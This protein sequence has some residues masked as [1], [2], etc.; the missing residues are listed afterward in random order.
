LQARR[1][2]AFSKNIEV[3]VVTPYMALFDFRKA[4]RKSF[5]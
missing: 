4:Y 5:K 3:V 1:L 2:A